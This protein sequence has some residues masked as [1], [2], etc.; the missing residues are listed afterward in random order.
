MSP[1]PARN[2]QGRPPKY[3]WDDWIET[4]ET[5]TAILSLVEGVHFH[6]SLDAMA[7]QLRIKAKKDRIGSL[8]IVKVRKYR[9]LDVTLN[10]RRTYPW[11]KWLDGEQ[12]VLTW[13]RDFWVTIEDFRHVARRAARERG[14]LLKTESRDDMIMI[15]AVP[16]P[17]GGSNALEPEDPQQL[18]L[19]SYVPDAKP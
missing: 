18:D 1:S 15:Q 4:L 9:R 17:A 7:C 11:D 14:M 3:P 6:C 2:R 13:G 12:R 19:M 8:K 10:R 16:R 5:P